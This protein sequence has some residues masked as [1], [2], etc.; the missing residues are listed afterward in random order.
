MKRI[1]FLFFFFFLCV[2]NQ[3]NVAQN[4][5]GIVNS[6]AAV[7][8]VTVNTATLASIGPFQV[9]DKVL[10]IQM[11]GALITTTNTA[12]FGTIT[13]LMSA[14]NFE[15]AF[16]GSIS[17]NTVTFTSNL[18][19]SYAV[20]GKV[21]LVRVPVYTNVT[22]AGN[23]TAQAWNGSTGGIVA[24]EAT[25]SITFN[26]NINVSGQGFLGG[27][28][29]TGWFGC[30]DP[31][32][33]NQNAGK[34]GEGI[35]IPPVT[36]DANRAPLANGGG[37]SNTGNPGAGGGAN[38]GIGGR[39]GNEFYGGCQLNTSFGLG[40]L[41]PS[42]ATYKA[43]MGGGGGGGYKDNGLNATAGSNGGGMVFLISPTING[44]N[45]TVDV[46]G[47]NVIGNTDSEGA[48]GGGAGGYVYYMCPNTTSNI[49]LDARGGNGGNIF[50][51]MWS[52]A[53]HGP[54]GGGGG[55]AIAFQQASVPANVTNLLAGGNPGMVLHTG[56]ACAGTSHGAAGGAPGIQ[57]FNFPVP[58]APVLPNLGPNISICPGQTV[59]LQ[60]STTFNSYLWN[61]GQTSATI[62]INSPGIYWVDVPS[63]C[64]TVRD[65]IVVGLNT[66]SFNV[67]PDITICQ[68]DF[69]IAT[70][71][72]PYSSIL[73]NNGAS[74][75]S[76]QVNSPGVYTA[77]AIGVNG[78][79]A[80]DS[81]EV[82]QNPTVFSTVIDSVC[83]GYSYN[84]NGQLLTQAGIYTDTLQNALGCDSII[85]LQLSLVQ[86]PSSSISASICAG[87][88]YLFN[89]QS[90]T[91]AGQY[92][93]TIPSVFGCDSLVQLNLNL[94]PLPTVTVQDTLVCTQTNLTLF[95]SGAVSYVW[96]V[97][98]NPNG[99]ITVAPAQTTSYSV[100]GIDAFGCISPT[101]ILTV[102]IDPTP[103]PNFYLNPDQVEIDDPT[104]TI[105]NVT[106][107][108]YEHTWTINGNSFVNNQSSFN[109]PLPFLEGS[110]TVQLVS[111]TAIGCKDSLILTATVRD[112]V[113]L[114][115]PNSF[116][117]DAEE[118][119]TVFLPVFSTGFTPKNYSLIIMNRWGEVIFESAN[120]FIGW[121]GRLESTLCTD[122]IYS[123]RISYQ[124]KEDEAP[125]VVLGHVNLLH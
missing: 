117:P 124:R 14:G 93:V 44:N 109:Y 1:L 33:A 97:P 100:Y 29:F 80:Q 61:N 92:A 51:T 23:V 74:T 65:S 49:N 86:I 99:S 15:F 20:S 50:S 28:V 108:N 54:G 56:P 43:Y 2:S 53:C 9:G 66:F 112:N 19:K 98:Q 60:T 42:Y 45:F 4:I 27:A 87:D 85:T 71:T 114:F 31:N 83:I 21:Q 47:A 5:F 91:S 3:K 122:G 36:M 76:I 32:Y 34:K 78:C 25:N 121:D 69:A 118:H 16:I 120:H 68:G 84:F 18:C 52:S 11:K 123:Y 107:G 111:E 13:N 12:A 67:G 22:I 90:L 63:G 72:G 88:T 106:A 37:G 102:S 17:G 125:I 41:A 96:D 46:K 94:L 6:Y 38:G 39:G 101:E 59:T 105:Y 79:S 10:I 75:G 57:V 81:M 82:F 110:Y 77:T 115:V 55:G 64:T 40:G 119:N 24:I 89:G 103:I 116:T 73:W 104:I 62:S 95:A 70:A 7:N 26:A 8:A 48:G 35:A 30:G 113:S 58:V